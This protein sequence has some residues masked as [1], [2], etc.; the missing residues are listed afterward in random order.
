M[1][2]LEA[3][4]AEIKRGAE[5]ILVEEELIAKLK[6]G[7]PLRV[8]LG[9]DPTAPDIHLGHTV[10]L[11]KLRQFQDLGHEVLL[12]IGD[13]T[14]QVGDPSGKN[15]TRPPL[16]PEQVAENAKTYAEQAFKVLDP[17]KT[18]I[19]Y[20]SSWLGELGATG[21]IRLAS[22][23]TVA[24]MLERDDF[25][26]R[27]AA[28]QSIAIH[29]FMYPLLQGYDSVALKADVE[30]G[31]TDQK[32]NLLMGRELQKDAGMSPQV[33]LTMPLLEGLDGI[34]KMS[35]SAGNYIGVD[36][37][38]NEMFGKIMS[39]SDELMWRY[40]E[41]L[42]RRSLDELAALKQQ[43]ADGA[44][45]RDT[46]IL[47]AKEI[48]TRYHSEAAAEQAH[49]DFVQRFQKNAI[50][51]DL[52]EVTLTAGAEGIGIANLLKDAGLVA[53]TSEALR[54]IKQGAVKVNGDKLEDGKLQ[55]QPGQAVYQVGKR[56]FA[57]VTVA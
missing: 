45:P 49:Q 38:P 24:R 31:G 20:N 14:A 34:K 18:Q 41:L 3:A 27:Y 8:K 7:R 35:K 33:V 51:D 22:K 4:L 53:S 48:I 47:L 40:F 19:V 36:E 26:K 50:P 17:A 23:L 25:K 39:L 30:L 10:I 11:N 57:K 37:A 42:S 55:V 5:E 21:M 46:K 6:E 16:T 9:M 2:Q 13:F 44:N 1:S 12:L 56:K 43:V 32:F 15:S 29:E 52:P 28:G 54:M